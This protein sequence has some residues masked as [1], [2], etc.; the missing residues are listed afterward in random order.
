VENLTDFELKVER[1]AS[2][3]RFVGVAPFSRHNRV[4]VS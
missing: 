3:H 2:R 1:R 4:L